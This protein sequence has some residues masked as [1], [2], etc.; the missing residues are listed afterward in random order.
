MQRRCVPGEQ[1]LMGQ[2]KIR[3]HRQELDEESLIEQ[4]WSEV[5]EEG[6]MRSCCLTR[7]EF[8]FCKEHLKTFWRSVAEQCKYT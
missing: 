1:V 2:R 4:W 5:G 7:T 8:Q 3:E 6:E